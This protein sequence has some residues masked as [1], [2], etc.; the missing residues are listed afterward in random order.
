VVAFGA[1]CSGG[2][3]VLDSVLPLRLTAVD[4]FARDGKVPD[5]IRMVHRSTGT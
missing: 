3:P 5:G 4:L 2:E 1:I